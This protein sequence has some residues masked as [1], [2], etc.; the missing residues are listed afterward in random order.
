MSSGTTNTFESPG[1]NVLDVLQSG[2]ALSPYQRSLVESFAATWDIDSFAAVVETRVMDETRLAHTLARCLG[3]DYV[4]HLT[5]MTVPREVFSVIP[6]AVARSRGVLPLGW[7]EDSRRF[8][9]VVANPLCESCLAAIRQHAGGDVC[10]SVAELSE[11]RHAIDR[12][13]PVECQV[14]CELRVS[15]DTND[16]SGGG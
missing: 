7:M 6:F 2:G 16:V 14:R 3:I 9:C 13:Y 15:S 11:I 12:L 8:W 1:R 5:G 10:L 4:A